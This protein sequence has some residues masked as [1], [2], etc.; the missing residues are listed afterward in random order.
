M[1]LATDIFSASLPAGPVFSIGRAPTKHE[2][3][4]KAIK[5]KKLIAYL[6][7]N[8]KK[9]KTPAQRA[10][11]LAE[12][13]KAAAGPNPFLTQTFSILPDCKFERP[14]AAAMW[15]MPSNFIGRFQHIQ[16]LREITSPL[17]SKEYMKEISAAVKKTVYVRGVL[18]K[19]LNLWREKRLSVK[20]EEDFFTMEKPHAA[21]TLVDWPGRQKWVFEATSL[22]RDITSRLMHNDGF[23]EDPQ[24]PRN[25]YTNLPLTR[26]Q[27]ISIWNQFNYLRGSCSFAFTAF[28]QSRFVMKKFKEEHS[29]ALRLA[30]LN[31]TMRDV[32]H[33]D[34]FDAMV[35]FARM[36]FEYEEVQFFEEVF[37]HALRN[38]PEH[39]IVQ[40][41]RGLCQK[42]NEA[43]IRYKDSP[44][45]LHGIH[46]KI[47]DSTIPLLTMQKELV[48]LRNEDIRRGLSSSIVA[49]SRASARPARTVAGAVVGATVLE[50]DIS[51][52]LAFIQNISL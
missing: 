9:K 19:F 18:R 13:K 48:A 7:K 39:L 32:N 6:K 29:V 1:S 2:R 43:E 45:I 31:K 20:N 30:A 24:L 33:Y 25:P 10:L 44:D 50:D 4:K 42:Y 14:I 37:K 27:I 36:A 41:W 3:E 22:M 17:W 15:M 26:A 40:K 11:A 23:F 8:Q 12:F 51:V 28:R 52:F 46:D 21:V 35:S 34:T 47:W 5:K 16:A 38:Y 49:I